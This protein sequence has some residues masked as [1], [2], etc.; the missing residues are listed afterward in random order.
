MLDRMRVR[1]PQCLLAVAT[2]PVESSLAMA[3]SPVVLDRAGL[4]HGRPAGR[5][6]RDPIPG[7]CQLR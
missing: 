4:P 2:F 6:G 3:S 7:L 5:Q 1:P